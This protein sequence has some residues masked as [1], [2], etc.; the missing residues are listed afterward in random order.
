MESSE[1]FAAFAG[2]KCAGCG[3]SKRRHNAFCAWCY[4]ELPKALRRALRQRFGS[5]F[6]QAYMG[7]LSWFRKNTFQGEHRA[8]QK[9]LWEDVS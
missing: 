8:K 7:C 2:M 3:G 1:I 5:G 4:R 6:E 9:G